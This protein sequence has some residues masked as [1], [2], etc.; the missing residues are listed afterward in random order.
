LFYQSFFGSASRVSRNAAALWKRRLGPRSTTFRRSAA[1]G[2]FAVSVPALLPGP[3]W[4][5]ARLRQE[6]GRDEAGKSAARKQR[7]RAS[8]NYR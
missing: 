6:A 5:G 4:H 1:V 8:A 2:L 3:L 7:R